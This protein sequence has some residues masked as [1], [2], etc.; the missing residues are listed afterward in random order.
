MVNIVIEKETISTIFPK[1]I[2][3]QHKWQGIIHVNFKVSHLLKSTI[4]GISF[5]VHVIVCLS[6]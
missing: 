4:Y 5:A 2:H 1:L 3:F 6:L